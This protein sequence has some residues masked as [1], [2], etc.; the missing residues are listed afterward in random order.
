MLSNPNFIIFAAGIWIGFIVARSA[1]TILILVGLG[2]LASCLTTLEAVDT[3][4]PWPILDSTTLLAHVHA[5][6]APGFVGFVLGYLLGKLR[7]F[8]E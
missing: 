3:P 1:V 4:P 5:W 2:L 8:R 7:V 6:Q